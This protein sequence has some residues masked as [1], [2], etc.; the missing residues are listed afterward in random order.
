MPDFNNLKQELEKYL[1]LDQIDKV[2]EAFLFGEKAHGKQ[3][4]RSGEPYI[5]HPLAVAK[6]LADMR[7]DTPTIIAAILHDVIEDTASDKNALTEQFG[8]EIAELV[9]GVTKLTQMH[10][11]SQAEAQ[12][13]NFRKMMMAMAKDIRVILI[14]LADR[15]HNMRTL[16]VLDPKKRNRIARETLEIYAPITNRLG[17][18]HMLIE[19]EDLSFATLYPMRC[20]ILLSSLKKA[21]GNRKEILSVI[22]NSLHNSLKKVGFTDLQ[23]FGR[24]KHLYSIYKKMRYKRIHFS[25]VMDIYA[26]RI[27]TPSVDMCYRVLGVVHNLFKPVPERFKDFIAI[28][29]SNGYQSLH[30]TLFGPYGVPIEIQIRTEEMD[31]VAE[32][33]IASHWLYK[34]NKQLCQKTHLRATEWIQEVLAIQENTGSSIEFIENIK[35]DLFPEE[36]Y[37]F[38]PKGKIVKLPKG[39]TP[40]DLAYAVHTEIGNTCIAA[41][42]DRRLVPLN[43]VIKSGQTAEIITSP[44]ARPNPAWLNFIVTGKAR[45]GIRHFLK[46]QQRLESIELGRDLFKKSLEIFSIN[47]NKISA[48]KYQKLLAELQLTSLEDLFEQIGLGNQMPQLVARR[49]QEATEISTSACDQQT[50]L[51]IKGT[52]GM[53]LHFAK[54]CYPI[55]D[56]PIEGVLE[57]GRGIIVHHADCKNLI[58]SPH[59]SEKYLSLRW[60]DNIEGTFE[61]PLTIEA[62]PQPGLLAT[63]IAAIAES[64]ADVID[65]HIEKENAIYKYHQ[66]ILAV[67]NRVHLAQV[68]RS[69]RKVNQMVKISR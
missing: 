20:S 7:L 24:E 67:K 37:V 6:I 27:I 15:L 30:T 26:F 68:I 65:I 54:C 32:N 57:A 50:P 11:E 51:T 69:V 16:S 23:F 36:V 25:E 8:L 1:P 43:S 39:G 18:Y 21:R 47:I 2:Y 56:D 14:K 61:V 29:K 64:G 22:E 60:E 33:G 28:P 10:F 42:I 58:R 66:F 13:E 59:L 62:I 3:V 40:V 31:Q 4:R 48:K 49:L 17:I 44:D 35:V 46:N 41:K 34:S 53:V 45:S 12:A 63:L 38:T 55:P 9:D 5:T 52:E 19:L